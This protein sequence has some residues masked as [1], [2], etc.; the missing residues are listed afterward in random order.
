MPRLALLML[1]VLLL[2]YVFAGKE[3]FD[4]SAYSHPLQHRRAIDSDD[5]E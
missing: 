5:E 4:P 2:I 3:A 1:I